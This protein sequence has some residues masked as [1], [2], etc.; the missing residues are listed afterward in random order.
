MMIISA[1]SQ[2]TSVVL[3]RSQP[4]KIVNYDG[5]SLAIS[6]KSRTIAALGSKTI[7][8]PNGKTF[9]LLVIA[10]NRSA[11]TFEFDTSSITVSIDGQKAKVYTYD[12]LVKAEKK[13]R[14]A[15]L[16]AAV[17]AGV[18]DSYSA[19]NSGYQTTTGTYS[20]T[21]YGGY[22]GSYN[23]YGNYTSTAYDYAAVQAAQAQVK[24]NNRARINGIVDA[25]NAQ[26]AR[27]R[28]TILK[29]TTM[30]R[31]MTYGGII[32]VSAP[33]LKEGEVQ[34]ID[35]TVRLAKDIHRFV[36]KRVFDE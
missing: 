19:A 21:I 8:A 20:S 3:D 5:Q 15:Q 32:S 25:S 22:G 28:A 26:L 4:Q 1:C 35:V 27:L 30:N 23:F 33:A 16:F 31:G 13:A 18:A 6:K 14:N 34:R 11:P 2:A 10:E 9:D 12:E 36:L 29:P 17:L 24:A 7:G